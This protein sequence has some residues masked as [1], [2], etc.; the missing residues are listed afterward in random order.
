MTPTEKLEVNGTLKL[1]PLANQVAISLPTSTSITNG[2]LNGTVNFD[3]GKA[4]FRNG[5]SQGAAFL[6]VLGSL[7]IGGATY[8]SGGSVLPQGN[9][10]VEGKVGIGTTIPTAKLEVA[11]T[12]TS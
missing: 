10:A 3:V 1:T 5:N 9:L 11:S 2:T 8:S 4:L 12:G 6:G 7:G